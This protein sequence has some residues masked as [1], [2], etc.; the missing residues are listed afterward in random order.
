MTR[1]TRF[2]ASGWLS[3]AALALAAGCSAGD[4]VVAY[5]SGPAAGGAT[6]DGGGVLGTFSAPVAIDGL[7][8]A[9][10]VLQDPSLSTDE[11]ELY[12]ASTKGGSL[13][14]WRSTRATTAD[15]WGAASLVQEL[16]SDIYDDQEPELTRDDLTMYF[17][18]DRPGAETGTHIWVSRRSGRAEPWGAPAQLQLTGTA[19]MARGPTIDAPQLEMIFYSDGA[20]GDYDL[21]RMWRPS[22]A[23][24]WQPPAPLSEINS[25]VFDWD[26]GLFQD[27]C[28]LVFGSRRGGTGKSPTSDLFETAAASDHGTFT[29]PHPLDA[30]NTKASEGDPW[31]SNDG[32]HIV[33]S[34]DRGGTVSRLYESWR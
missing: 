10:D 6:P 27:G 17:A 33:F 15:A 25:T 31:L 16:S 2:I 9:T 24:P 23:E 3:L 28:G 1:T 26:P 5:L 29:A 20:Q 8:D 12:F 19:M 7:L 30:L 32:H 13:D 21:Y 4:R 14:I 34:S 11:L 18:S 22:I